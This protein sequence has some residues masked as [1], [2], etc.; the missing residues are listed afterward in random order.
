MET[1]IEPVGSTS[2]TNDVDNIS[3]EGL[4]ELLKKN[5][6]PQEEPAPVK[7]QTE[8]ADVEEPITESTQ[9]VEQ[10]EEVEGQLTDEETDEA[11]AQDADEAEESDGLDDKT[12]QSINSRIGKLTSQRKRA[13]EQREAA[14]ESLQKVKA[15]NQKLHEQLD[16]QG[17]QSLLAND[18]LA[19]VTS[20]RE[21]KDRAKQSRD[22]RRWAQRNPDGGEYKFPDGTVQEY[23]SA[24]AENILKYA[25][26]ML[27]EHIPAREKWLENNSK[28]DVLASQ[29][30]P[31]WND[32]T[33]NVYGE[34]QE[35][36]REMPELKRFHNH[37]QLV[38]V[39][40]MGL[41][42]Y[43]NAL[44]PKPDA[45]KPKPKKVAKPSEPTKVSSPTSVPPPA[46]AT[47]AANAVA[48]AEKWV[49]ESNGS[50]DAVMQLLKARRK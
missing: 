48:D 29:H 41:A 34:Y 42:A 7:E 16:K 15:E 45:A 1:V 36:I 50:A 20:K 30:F 25:D 39:F 43:N 6:Q 22:W 12:Q 28:M 47:K 14:E 11:E 35:I 44:S 5:A 8:E 32:T 26:D 46:S 38:G 3:L 24:Q 18:P 40:H 13:I 37:K 49:N 23:D 31:A 19:D 4:G 10:P 17:T 9:E 2:A 33:S 27:E 21:L